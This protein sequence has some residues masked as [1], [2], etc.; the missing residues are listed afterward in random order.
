[1]QLYPGG[2]AQNLITGVHLVVSLFTIGTKIWII[3]K[4]GSKRRN[5]RHLDF[6]LWISIFLGLVHAPLLTRTALGMVHGGY[7]LCT[8]PATPME[9]PVVPGKAFGVM[10]T[11]NMTGTREGFSRRHVN[12]TCHTTEDVFIIR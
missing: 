4:E 3:K 11:R 8:S 2:S 6:T 9:K 5:T 12:P 10:G 7:F 1:M